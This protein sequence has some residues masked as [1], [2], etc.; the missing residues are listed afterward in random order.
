MG[1]SKHKNTQAFRPMARRP[2]SIGRVCVNS[3]ATT[4]N[5]PEMST[6]RMRGNETTGEASV[7]GGEKTG[8]T[9]VAG[10]ETTGEAAAWTT[11][12]LQQAQRPQ[13]LQQIWGPPKA[14]D[15]HEALDPQQASDP[16]ER[17]FHRRLENHMRLGNHR[18]LGKHRRLGGRVRGT[19][20]DPFR[21]RVRGVIQDICG[22]PGRRCVVVP[23]THGY[24]GRSIVFP[25]THRDKGSR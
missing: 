16:K 9:L 8:Q 2:S 14:W 13:G 19:V 3:Q 11:K 15:S 18:R 20:Q 10:K 5:W 1:N 21:G 24:T 12:V 23:D 7:D 25:N 4:H 17:G 6:S 22:N